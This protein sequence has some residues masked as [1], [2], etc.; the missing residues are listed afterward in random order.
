MTRARPT[1]LLL[2]LL[3]WAG[4]AQ[5]H[6][7][8]SDA[9]YLFLADRGIC[10]WEVRGHPDPQNAVGP[11]GEIGWCQIKPS[12][13]DLLGIPLSHLVSP[14]RSLAVAAAVEVL[15]WCFREGWHGTYRQAHCYN[16]GPSARRGAAHAYARQIASDH[17][18]AWLLWITEIRLAKR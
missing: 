14:D 1:L 11:G 3:L 6:E 9:E 7:E 18:T 13:A 16:A 10:T 4:S 15:R 8:P 5:A 2:A 17:A 12:T